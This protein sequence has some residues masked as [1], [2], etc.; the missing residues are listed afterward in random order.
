[1]FS[2]RDPVLVPNAATR[3]QVSVLDV[4]LQ[5]AA[6]PTQAQDTAPPHVAG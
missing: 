4:P 2:A 5:V 1:M 3:L 6:P